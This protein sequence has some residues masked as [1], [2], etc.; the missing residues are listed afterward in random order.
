MS[1]RNSS[2]FSQSATSSNPFR[3]D[4]PEGLNRRMLATHLNINSLANSEHLEELKEIVG[5]NNID[6]MGISETKLCSTV[7]RVTSKEVAIDGY[8][9]FRTDRTTRGGGG[10][11]MYVK[12]QLKPKMVGEWSK[13]TDGIEQ[14]WVKV[15]CNK[16][17]SFY[18]C[19]IYLP[20]DKKPTT[21]SST[22]FQDN[23]YPI[24]ETLRSQNREF[25][26]LGDFNC[27]LLEPQKPPGKAVLEMC[28]TLGLKQH[29]EQP[30]R[31]IT[32]TLIDLIITSRDA[33]VQRNKV[34]G[35]YAS[36]C[37]DGIHSDHRLVWVCLDTRKKKAPKTKIVIRSKR[38]YNEGAFLRDLSEQ[39]WETGVATAEEKAERFDRLFVEVLDKH[40]PKK[41]ITLKRGA[42]PWLTPEIRKLLDQKQR[43]MDEM[44]RDPSKKQAFRDIKNKVP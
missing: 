10:V 14:L 37:L 6:I 13:I 44:K 28:S 35:V 21:F 12:E 27:D 38:H 5:V 19:V 29:I 41:E 18:A 22:L 39:Q 9:L 36:G 20:P 25:V 16:S 32:N 24:I 31:V 11:A 33:L 15:Q 40:L 3:I 8:D 23:L 1:S 43:L 30:T 17:R 4:L 26:I 7:K 42:A 34:T 2:P